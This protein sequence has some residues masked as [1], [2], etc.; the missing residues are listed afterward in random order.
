MAEMETAKAKCL[1]GD[2]EEAVEYLTKLLKKSPKDLDA[3]KERA[4]IH[5]KLKMVDAA[6][7]DVAE[8]LKLKPDAAEFT[9]LR[10]TIYRLEG[11]FEGGVEIMNAVIAKHG[12]D[13]AN[14]LER[15][16]C[17]RL[18]MQYQPSI[19]DYT[20][21]LEQDPKSADAYA[22]RGT[23]YWLGNIDA[24]IADCENALAIDPINGQALY[25]IGEAHRIS[26]HSQLALP[27]FTTAIDNNK[28]NRMDEVDLYACRGLCLQLVG[29]R[30]EEAIQDLEK[31]FVG[32]PERQSQALWQFKACHFLGNASYDSGLKEHYYSDSAN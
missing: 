20:A 21:A 9:R 10:A 12:R 13:A 11:D 25:T 16:H 31:A 14:L 5:I 24:C 22:G 28:F 30:N 26:G 3:L 27:H 4:L 29:D 15:G 7:A 8:C 2:Y 1:K 6:R 19:D 32:R 17:L 18:C 23:T